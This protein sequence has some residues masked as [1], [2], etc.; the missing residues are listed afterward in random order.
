VDETEVMKFPGV[1]V[2]LTPGTPSGG[3]D[4]TVVNHGGLNVPN[5]KEFIAKLEAAGV[6]MDPKDP[7]TGRPPGL[8]VG[9]RVWN[10]VYTPDGF[11]VEILD[12]RVAMEKGD[13]SAPTSSD[14]IH[15]YL[16]DGLAIGKAQAW[17]AKM[18]GAVP[19][20]PVPPA[21]DINALVP[22]AK[23]NFTRS[24]TPPVPTQG[25][26]LDHIGFEVQDLEAFCKKLEA[27]GVQFDAPYS[28]TRHRSFANAELSDPWGTSIELTEGL[29]RF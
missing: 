19:T 6:K 22:G 28:K 3:S 15:F 7:A 10:F 9:T 13:L 2:F 20:P 5:G 24:A 16:P 23:L 29:S 25:R 26:A 14:L 27:N 21:R 4:G 11:R 12:N 1:L 17:Y 8:P 18:L